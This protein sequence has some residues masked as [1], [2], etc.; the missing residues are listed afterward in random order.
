MK[1]I[2]LF[3][4]LQAL[5]DKSNEQYHANLIVKKDIIYF[6]LKSVEWRVQY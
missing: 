3:Y 1:S 4:E 5:L 6:N 2:T